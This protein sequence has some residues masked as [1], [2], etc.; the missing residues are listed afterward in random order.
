MKKTKKSV[1]FNEIVTIIYEPDSLR[2]DLKLARISDFFQ[3]KAD[4]ERMKRNYER[5][6]SPILSIE[7]RNKIM[8]KYIKNDED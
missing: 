6:L 8:N 5:I 3:R 1:R 4:N 2:E 7:H